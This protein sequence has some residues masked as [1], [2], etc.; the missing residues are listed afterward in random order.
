MTQHFDEAIAF[1]EEQLNAGRNLLIHC[2]AGVSR[3]A[4]I[5]IAYLMTK[6]QWTYDE[7]LEFLKSKR[8]WVRPNFG[9]EKQLRDYEQRL[10]AMRRSRVSSLNGSVPPQ[11]RTS[12][13]TPSL[14]LSNLLAGGEMMAPNNMQVSAVQQPVL[15]NFGGNMVGGPLPLQQPDPAKTHRSNFPLSN[16]L[17]NNGVPATYPHPSLNGSIDA[18][19]QIPTGYQNGFVRKQRTVGLSEAANIKTSLWTDVGSICSFADAD[20]FEFGGRPPTSNV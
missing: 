9:F 12:A 15:P 10:N 13:S 14:P 3:S 2:H 17:T 18:A 19:K 5:T 11:L 4:T 20:E 6:N 1:I 7:A 16:H 8:K